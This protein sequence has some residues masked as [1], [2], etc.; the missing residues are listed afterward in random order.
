[1]ETLA[2]SIAGLAGTASCLYTS[3][4]ILTFAA[5]LRDA[6][7]LRKSISDPRGVRIA[8]TG[9]GP[10]EFIKSILAYDGIAESLLLIPASL[11]DNEKLD[12]MYNAGCTHRLGIGEENPVSLGVTPNE[13]ACFG[14]TH[15]LL[16]TS[17]TTGK[18]KLIEHTF[19][20]LTRTLKRDLRRGS[21]YHWGLLYDPNRFAGL[22]V[23][24]QALLAGS[25][26]TL[27]EGQTFQEQ[28]ETLL[29]HP[30]N[31]LS[32]TP[33][34]WRKLLMD[35]RI[36]GLSLRQITLGGEIADQKTIDVL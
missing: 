14:P 5:L 15:W 36:A 8:L 25:C 2:Q 23:V 34:L 18:P 17:G 1:M 4:R 35:G 31:A 33:S 19:A 30:V 24:L 32:A 28:V 27:P 20:S 6:T 10:V 11:G 22:Q 29:C 26:L 16:A 9:L 21:E 3:R 12:L 13:S 7:A